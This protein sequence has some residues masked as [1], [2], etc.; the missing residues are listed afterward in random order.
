MAKAIEQLLVLQACDQE[1]RRLRKEVADI[2]L[3]QQQIESRMNAHQE[4]L[5]QAEHALLEA[6][7]RIKHLEGEIEACRQKILK[8]R[9]QQLQIKSNDGYKALEKEI[10]GTQAEIRQREDEELAA[11]EAVEEAKAG[12]ESRRQALAKEQARVNEE[13]KT[14]QVRNQ[15]ISAE[16]ARKES[17]RKTLAAG[18][19]PGWLAR[20][21]R[22]FAKQ[23][24][25]AIALVEHGTCGCCHMKL[26]PAQVVDA[27]KADTLTPCA[28]CGRMLYLPV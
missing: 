16:L 4:G 27:R 25:A 22:I 20:Y 12:A 2:P 1:I 26:S 15:E 19:E 14:F 8:F 13:L 23:R 18:I 9:E 24:D 17:E 5:A 3:R 11:M 28:F 7:S 10:A 6:K 21:E